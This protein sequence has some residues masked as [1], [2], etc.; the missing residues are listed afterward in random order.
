MYRWKCVYLTRF[1][2]IHKSSYECKQCKAC[3]HVLNVPLKHQKPCAT[4]FGWT[5]CFTEK[6]LG[7]PKKEILAPHAS[8]STSTHQNSHRKVKMNLFQK[9]QR[10]KLIWNNRVMLLLVG[11]LQHDINLLFS[12]ILK[13]FSNRQHALLQPSQCNLQSPANEHSG[14]WTLVLIR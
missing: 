5:Y 14:F 9:K 2:G 3:T 13:L 6:T 1:E 12:S 7:L 8:D 10:Y 4:L 11:L